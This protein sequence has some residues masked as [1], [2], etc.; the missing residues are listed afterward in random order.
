MPKMEA[1]PSTELTGGAGYTYE[2]TVVAY[3]LAALLCEEGAAGQSGKVVRVAVQQY[4]HGAPLDDVVITFYDQTGERRLDLQVKRSLTISATERNRDFRKILS[5]SL[6]TR[7]KVDFRVNVDR[8]GFV[9]ETVTTGPIRTFRRLL[10]WARSSP[11]GAEFASRFEGTGATATAE[12]TLRAELH[13]L[14]TTTDDGEADF[15]RHFVAPDLAG[16]E[17]D[18]ALFAS[19]ANRLEQA[20]TPGGDAT[21]RGLF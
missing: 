7:A 18:G 15:Y 12:R 13:P 11:T 1:S 14:L 20:L 5:D 6:A 17:P 16:L 3:Y 4:P 9:A 21:G 19:I 10:D 8:Y 2:D